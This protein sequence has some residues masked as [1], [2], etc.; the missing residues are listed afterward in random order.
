MDV[1]KALSLSESH[2]F[3]D[4]EL[5][6][7]KNERELLCPS[8]FKQFKTVEVSKQFLKYADVFKQVDCFIYKRYLTQPDTIDAIVKEFFKLPGLGD[9]GVPHM[10]R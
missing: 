7:V 4:S 3:S 9:Y 2:Q 10:T 8:L 6:S 1:T 5:V